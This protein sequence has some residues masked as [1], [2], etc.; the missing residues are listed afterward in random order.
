MTMKNGATISWISLLVILSA[1]SNMRLQRADKAYDLMQY[2]KAERLYERIL[3]HKDLRSARARLADSYRQHNSMALSAGHYGQLESRLPLTGDTALAYGEVLM[4]LGEPGKASDLFLRV[5]QQTPENGRALDLYESTQDYGSFYAD[6]GRFYVNRLTLPGIATAFGAIPFGKGLLV[7]GE[8]VIRDRHGNP[9][10]ERPFLDLF[11]CESRTIVTWK[12]AIGIPGI[13]NGAYHEGPAAISPDGR[14]L[15]FTRSNYVQRKLQKDQ[16]NT[17]HLKLFRATLDSTGKWVD[18]HEFAYNSDTW[19]T[20]HPALSSDGRTLYFASD[21]PG[22]SGGADIWRCRDN[23]TGWSEPENLGPTV[24]TA[25]DELFPTLNGSALHFSSTAHRNMGGLDIFEVHEQDGQWSDPVNLNAPINTPMDDFFFVLDS[26]SKAG[27]LSSDREGSDQ[28][29]AFSMYEPVYYLEG[30]VMDEQE[31][32][33]PNV[34]V[35][36]VDLGTGAGDP[37]LTGP[38][39][40]FG[41]SLKPNTDYDLRSSHKDMLTSSISLSTKGLTRSDT[42]NTTIV[43]TGLRIGEAIAVNNIYYDYD[44]WAIRPDAVP[45][46]DKLARLFKDNPGIHFE[47][48]SHTDSRGGDLYNLVLSDARAN[49]AVNY[50]IQRGVDPDRI[51]ARG[52]GE[53]IPVN[54]CSNGVNCSEE[55][56]QANRRT[57]FK[58]IGINGLAS[59]TSEP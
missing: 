43:L 30:I 54:A 45:E 44:D 21:R 22:G 29:Y 34:E 9:W 1:C 28:V 5:L 11:Y 32:Y 20:G 3:A 47:L 46:L 49:S 50:L 16:Q 35:T 19:S 27:Y 4:A 58:V 41:F 24:N 51:T 10:N 15:Y 2:P 53:A 57:E 8:E 38:D 36:L 31:R 33:L 40:K 37:R 42:L 14:H 39:G 48:G 25:G 12:E 18:L 55:E 23:G 7:A 13:V 56:H 26:T 6:S 52:Y 59:T 17:S